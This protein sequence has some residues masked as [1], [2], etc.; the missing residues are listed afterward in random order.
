MKI[1]MY[2]HT[3]E[4]GGAQ[5][6]AIELGAQ[7]QR[8][9][10]EVV[11]YSKTGQLAGLAEGRGLEFVASPRPHQRPD[12][13]VAAALKR[14]VSSRG[15]EVVHG[16]EWPPILE[17]EIANRGTDAV[18]FGSVMSMSAAPFIPKDL[19]LTV[20]TRQI[21][22][23]ER[24]FG[25][26]RL[27][28]LEPPVDTVANAPGLELGQAGFRARM[29][30]A[31]DDVLV[32]IIGRLVR[33]L[34]LEGLL[35]AT[36]VIGELSERYPV[37][38]VIVGDGDARDDVREAAEAAN[39]RAGRQV[40]VMAGQMDDP[41]PAYAAADIAL[42]TGGSAL[43]SLAFGTPLIVQGE[44]GFWK[45]LEPATVDDFHWAGWYGVGDSG[46][47]GPRRLRDALLPLLTDPSRRRELGAFGRSVA[48]EYSLTRTA[49]LLVEFYEDART[50]RRPD[51]GPIQ[52]WRFAAMSA[53]RTVEA[54]LGRFRPHE[55]TED[56]N[57][58][59]ATAGVRR[60]KGEAR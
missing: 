54:Q 43:R 56:Y 33:A 36:R 12:L 47:D 60:F 55:T 44:L 24:A 26:S 27:F 45:L 35:A 22:A 17:A 50:R 28:L 18:T 38:L 29:G 7:L 5:L 15:M 41:R 25:R 8:D 13:R 2:P 6:N 39:A 52:T 21:E 1:V 57:T 20:G 23:A 10:H 40:V 16:W 46:D 58:L 49:Q 34:K 4:I 14:L 3:L 37:K 30:V 53:R 51:P 59:A 48:N 42:G 9:G 31:E 19:P 11:L 32:V